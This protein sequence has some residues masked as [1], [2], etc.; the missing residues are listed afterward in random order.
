MSVPTRAGNYPA[1]VTDNDPCFNDDPDGMDDYDSDDDDS[2]S[3][4]GGDGW[5]IV[6]T[7]WDTDDAINGP[8]DGEIEKCPNCGGS[9]EAKDMTF[10]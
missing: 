10:W 4:C 2:C 5:G 8:Y 7:D 9:G 1:G 6:G 3:Y